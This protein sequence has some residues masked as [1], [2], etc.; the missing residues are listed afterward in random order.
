MRRHL[1][2]GRLAIVVDMKRHLRIGFVVCRVLIDFSIPV[3]FGSLDF[4]PGITTEKLGLWSEAGNT[5][6][7]ALRMFWLT[8]E[9]LTASGSVPG[10]RKLNALLSIGKW[11]EPTKSKKG[12]NPPALAKTECQEKSQTS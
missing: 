1:L 3:R 2:H 12:W 8:N 9:M 4:L 5:G 10:G 6:L 7:S 11:A